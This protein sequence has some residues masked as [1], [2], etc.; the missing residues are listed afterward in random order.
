MNCPFDRIAIY[1]DLGFEVDDIIRDRH[2]HRGCKWEQRRRI[3]AAHQRA[4]ARHPSKAAGRRNLGGV[5]I[6]YDAIEGY[7][8]AS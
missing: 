7:G 6:W 2:S 5:S 8:G 1:V 4:I 3:K